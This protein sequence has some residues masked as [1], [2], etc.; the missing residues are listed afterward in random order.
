M[1]PLPVPQTNGNGVISTPYTNG[2]GVIKSAGPRPGAL[3]VSDPLANVNPA[4]LLIIRQAVLKPLLFASWIITHIIYTLIYNIQLLQTL[5]SWMTPTKGSTEKEEIVILTK[6]TQ[7]EKLP[8]HLVI[9]VHKNDTS[10][11]NL[12]VLCSRNISLQIIKVS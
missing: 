7:F 11:H 1:S 3:A 6:A 8:K 10:L 4:V 5:K 9:A 2:N 12:Q